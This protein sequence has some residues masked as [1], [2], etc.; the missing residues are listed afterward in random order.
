MRQIVDGVCMA[1]DVSADVSYET[2]F[3]AVINAPAPV[4]AAARAASAVAARVDADCEPRLFSE[5]FA[6]LA[7]ARPGCFIL[8]GNGTH[9]A[10]SQPLHSADYDFNDAT[11]TI[12]SSFWVRLAEQQLSAEDSP[13]D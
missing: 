11:L 9:G 7:A 4:Q 12:G 1:H 8:M 10:H 13:R 2:I 6:H 3:P 5:D